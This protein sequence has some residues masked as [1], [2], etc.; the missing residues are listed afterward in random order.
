M[1]SEVRVN[2]IQNRSGLGTITVADTGITFAGITTFLGNI[3]VGSGSSITVG[4]KFI[5][6]SGIGLGATTTTGRN[7]GINTVAGTLIF[8][9]TTNKVEMYN[10][11]EWQTILSGFTATGGTLTISGGKM[12]HTFTG[13]GTFTVTSGS[14]NVEYLVVAGGGGGAHSNADGRQSSGGGA[15]GFRTG[16]GLPVSPGSYTI[17]VGAGGPAQSDGND[18]VFSSITSLKGGRGGYAGGSPGSGGSGTVGSGGGQGGSGSPL[19]PTIAPGTPGQGNPGGSGT[20]FPGGDAAGGGGGA[21]GAGGNASG[22]TAGGGGLGLYSSISG[23]PV[24][25]AGGAGNNPSPLGFGGGFN[26]SD[27]NRTGVANRGGGGKGTTGA[28]GSGIVIISY[29]S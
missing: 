2:Q 22:S 19:T 5:S 13:S 18:S 10:G 17:T 4:D 23:S 1:A 28:G 14:A 11:T 3:T 7:A 29:P 27:P 12:I 16:S 20:G 25:Y 6:S 21:G 8:N 26:G 9:A 24:G 15:G